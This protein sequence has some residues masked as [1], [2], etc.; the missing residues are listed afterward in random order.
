[1]LGP[2]DLSAKEAEEL[3]ASF[4]A[5]RYRNGDTGPRFLLVPNGMVHGHPEKIS[6]APKIHYATKTGGYLGKYSGQQAVPS[7]RSG[8]R[9]GSRATPPASA[10]ASGSTSAALCACK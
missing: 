6:V 2:V 4:E 7:S 9:S 5:T 3:N 8:S 10:S 1:M